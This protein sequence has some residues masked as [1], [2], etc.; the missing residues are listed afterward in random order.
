ME[1]KNSE[2]VFC[3]RYNCL[4][5]HCVKFSPLKREYWSSAVNVLTNSLK[6]LHITKSDFFKLNIVCTD[7]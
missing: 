5:I 2:K 6:I 3:F 1:K 4:S 7:R